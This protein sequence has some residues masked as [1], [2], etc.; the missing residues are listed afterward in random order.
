M[1]PEIH[2][3]VIDECIK[4]LTDGKG[5]VVLKTD[6]R[7]ANLSTYTMPL[8]LLEILPGE[9]S[10]QLLGGVTMMEWGFAMNS[11]VYSPDAHGGDVTG[12]ATGLKQI[13]DDIRKHFS[14]RTWLTTGMPAIEAAYGFR[15]TLSGLTHADALEAQDGLIN[16][17]R[18]MFDSVA[19]DDSTDSIVSST[20]NLEH[21][22]PLGGIQ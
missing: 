3:A 7:S 15:F 20:S 1:T 19:I 11:Y 4:L 2:Q 10:R 18:I 9:D 14:L 17:Y 13:I 8:L 6:F 22:L 16:G 21:V 5:T 12:F